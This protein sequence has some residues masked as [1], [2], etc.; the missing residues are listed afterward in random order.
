MVT[1]SDAPGNAP[2]NA[3]A[4]CQPH[5]LYCVPMHC[6]ASMHGRTDGR[7]NEDSLV[8]VDGYGSRT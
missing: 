8:K 5:C 2:G 1:P 3:D 6:Y 4:W 7:T